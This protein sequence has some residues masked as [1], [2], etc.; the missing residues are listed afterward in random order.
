MKV[1]E[2]MNMYTDTFQYPHFTWETNV[3]FVHYGG[4]WAVPIKYNIDDDD[5]YELLDSING[6]FFTGGATEL[7]DGKTG[8]PLLNS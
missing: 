4:S 2:G 6:V 8:V 3:N 5:L 7:F 1:F